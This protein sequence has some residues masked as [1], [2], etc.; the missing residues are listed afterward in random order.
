MLVALYLRD[1]HHYRPLK[2][3]IKLKVSPPFQPLN[4]KECIE[5]Q[6][7]VKSETLYCDACW[8]REKWAVLERDDSF[9]PNIFAVFNFFITLFLVFR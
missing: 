5:M 2:I 4:K 1:I 9:M 3:C 6:K 7:M 8:F